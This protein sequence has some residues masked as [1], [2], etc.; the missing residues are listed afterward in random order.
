MRSKDT[1]HRISISMEGTSVEPTPRDREEAEKSVRQ[2]EKKCG[3]CGGQIS[4]RH[5]K[6]R[7]Y[8]IL[9]AICQ[10]PVKLENEE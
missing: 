7:G 5:D 3:Q 6:R 1:R 4:L 8:K 9:E 2:L 10:C